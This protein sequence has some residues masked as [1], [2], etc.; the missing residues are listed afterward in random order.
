MSL[1]LTA[2]QIDCDQQT[3]SSDWHRRSSS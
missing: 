3:D 2:N 1:M